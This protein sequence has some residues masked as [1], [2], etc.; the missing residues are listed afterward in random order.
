MKIKNLS[1]LIIFVISIHICN[2]Q[3]S[4]SLFSSAFLKYQEGD[5]TGSITDYTAVISAKPDYI[6][7]YYNRAVAYDNA[8]LYDKALSDFNHVISLQPSSDTYLSR[9][10]V[11][12]HL[13]MYNQA[14]ADYTLALESD[15]SFYIALVARADAY[16]KMG[17][18]E[19]S[20]KDYDKIIGIFPKYAPIY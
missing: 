2:A 18:N 4:D 6:N 8:K 15:P 1:A 14:I 5:F 12:E 7:A 19:Q 11:Y 17:A 16:F 9:G 20:L 10:Q 13:T 3:N